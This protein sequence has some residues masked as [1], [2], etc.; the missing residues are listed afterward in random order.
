[1]TP[2]TDLL[3]KLVCLRDFSPDAGDVDVAI[4]TQTAKG[5][6]GYSIGSN[7]PTA[8]PLDYAINATGITRV[9][10]M[11]QSKG[12]TLTIG[13]VVRLTLHDSGCKRLITGTGLQVDGVRLTVDPEDQPSLA[14]VLGDK[15]WYFECNARSIRDL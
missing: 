14:T 2:P 11:V 8:T 3:G 7:E 12:V 9:E 5:I 13:T 1:M 15:A 6:H 10:W 4:I